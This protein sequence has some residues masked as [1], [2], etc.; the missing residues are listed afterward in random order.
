MAGDGGNRV[1]YLHNVTGVPE[2]G[3]QCGE[4]STVGG[5][6]NLSD[7][8]WRRVGRERETKADDETLNFDKLVATFGEREY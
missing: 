3:V 5:V 2:G 4:L 7:Q 6:G 8:E 1:G